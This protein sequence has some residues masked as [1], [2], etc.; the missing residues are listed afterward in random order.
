[1]CY[2]FELT[3]IK[4]PYEFVFDGLRGFIFSNIY[5]APTI[6]NP[7]TRVFIGAQ[8]L[9][10][11][12]IKTNATC[13]LVWFDYLGNMQQA[14]TT[15]RLL[16]GRVEAL[17]I[18]KGDNFY[19]PQKKYIIY[20]GGN[21]TCFQILIDDMIEL[22]EKHDACVIGFNPPGVGMSPGYT[23]L[24]KYCDSVKLV[25]DNLARNGVP[26]SKILVFGHSLGGGIA[27]R[28]VKE[29]R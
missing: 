9:A 16:P 29:Y 11:S 10:Q 3:N 26:Y 18:A 8:F 24:D 20:I 5:P 22:H 21:T 14:D 1:M 6:V 27:A 28:V 4:S 15:T 25:I 17:F 12:F 23:D 7:R 2:M 19:N 13:K